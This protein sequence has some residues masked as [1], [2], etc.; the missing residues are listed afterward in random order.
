MIGARTRKLPPPRFTGTS[1]TK[2]ML[3]DVIK[4]AAHSLMEAPHLFGSPRPVP[5]RRLRP[6]AAPFSRA[7]LRG[8]LCSGPGCKR[9]AVAQWYTCHEGR[10]RPVCRG[11]DDALNAA[12]LSYFDVAEQRIAKLRKLN[13]RRR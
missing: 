7:Q 5:R 10:H 2:T 11:C 6:R 3:D 12:V 13:R 1:S 9:A 8:A 4:Q